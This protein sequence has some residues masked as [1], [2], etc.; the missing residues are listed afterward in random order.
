MHVI[1][2]MLVSFSGIQKQR[3]N[4]LMFIITAIS[5]Q[6]LSIHSKNGS[7]QRACKTSL[8]GKYLI[9]TQT[10]PCL[11]FLSFCI[12]NK[13]IGKKHQTRKFKKKN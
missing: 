10:N 7:S 2:V 1:L 12:P 8:D 5:G 13:S 9:C 6:V 3:Q 11:R 4:D